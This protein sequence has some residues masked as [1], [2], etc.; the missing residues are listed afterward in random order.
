MI[1]PHLLHLYV[2]L[3]LSIMQLARDPAVAPAIAPVVLIA[4]VAV[5]SSTTNSVI[6]DFGYFAVLIFYPLN[7]KLRI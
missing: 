6:L 5:L 4:T 3:I 1:L 7:K 2:D